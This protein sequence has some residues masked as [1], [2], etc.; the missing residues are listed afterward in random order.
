MLIGMNDGRAEQ[1]LACNGQGFHVAGHT[2]ARRRGTD[3]GEPDAKRLLGAVMNTH[4][5]CSGIEDL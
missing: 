2:S 1:V 3:A 4:F 5:P